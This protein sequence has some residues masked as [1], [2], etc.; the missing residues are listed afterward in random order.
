MQQDHDEFLASLEDE[1]VVDINDLI[2]D[3]KPKRKRKPPTDNF[4]LRK[5]ALVGVYLAIA[6]VLAVFAFLKINESEHKTEPIKDFEAGGHLL[7]VTY[8]GET[9][10]NGFRVIITQETPAYTKPDPQSPVLENLIPGM[11]RKILITAT[12]PF[13]NEWN[14]V[15]PGYA[16]IQTQSRDATVPNYVDY[17][18]D[19]FDQVLSEFDGIAPSAMT[20]ENKTRMGM[21]YYG[22]EDYEQ[23]VDSFSE[24]IALDARN[25]LLYAYRADAYTDLENYEL[26]LVDWDKAIQMSGGT[27]AYNRRGFVSFHLRLFDAAGND[28]RKTIELNPGYGGAYSNLGAVYEIQQLY[29]QAAFQYNRAIELDV[30]MVLAYN[31]RAN[32][33]IDGHY[34]NSPYSPLD[35]YNQA[36]MLDPSDSWSYVNR[37]VYYSRN[38]QNEEA[39]V[40]LNKALEIDPHYALAYNNRGSVYEDMGKSQTALE[41]FSMAVSIDPTLAI[42]F[43]NLGEI[44]A[45]FCHYDL[46]IYYYDRALEVNPNYEAA[47]QARDELIDCHKND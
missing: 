36:L 23:A 40:D 19:W 5:L 25:P 3:L 22:K 31:G 11:T 12:D 24:A 30:F 38:G 21:L 16:W 35:D 15:R 47:R 7:T 39:L 6:A 13:G 32:L 28:F 10:P 41:D 29:D 26:A 18:T 17:T 37:A 27:I 14:Y 44:Y 33:V 20:A 34:P 2:S 45:E 9:H 1:S 46:A 4:N 43:Y 42:G 8:T